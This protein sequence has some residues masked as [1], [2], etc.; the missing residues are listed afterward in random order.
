MRGIPRLHIVS[1][2]GMGELPSIVKD[3]IYMS[4]YFSYLNIL[5]LIDVLF[6]MFFASLTLLY[7]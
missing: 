4:F 6:F 3:Y 1:V 7:R 5:D 2:F